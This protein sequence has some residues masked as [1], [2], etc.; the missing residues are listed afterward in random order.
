MTKLLHILAQRKSSFICNYIN[1]SLAM[2]VDEIDEIICKYSE[3]ELFKT[4]HVY[5]RHY[6]L[7]FSL[8]V[9]CEHKKFLRRVLEPSR[10][11][12]P[13][14]RKDSSELKLS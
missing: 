14:R 2:H 13:A 5:T 9:I 11:F 12:S 3:N 7:F 8:R 4:M 10:K 1:S 6:F